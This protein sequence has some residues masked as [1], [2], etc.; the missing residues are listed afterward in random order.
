M[1]GRYVLAAPDDLSERFTANQ[2]SFTINPNYNAAPSQFMPVIVEVEPDHWQIQRM[3]WGL[4]PRWTSKKPMPPPINARAETVADKPMFRNLVTHKRCLVPATGFYEW[5]ARGAGEKK[6]P[7]FIH[8]SDQSIFAFAGLWDETRPE[9]APEDVAGS[10]TIITTSANEAMSAFHHRMPVILERNE[11]DLWLASD[12]EASD[13]VMPLLDQYPAARI[14]AFPVS[15]RVNSVRNNDPDLMDPIDV[16][17][18]EEQ[19]SLF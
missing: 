8:V 11:E 18:D 2:L 9:D 16:A 12:V 14:E 4:I 1:C 7:F 19:G 5:Q 10:F 6:Q 17:P 3:H 15:T 13:M